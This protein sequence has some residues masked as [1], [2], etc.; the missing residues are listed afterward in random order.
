[1]L[2]ILQMSIIAHNFP[3]Y[4]EVYTIVSQF[5]K[6]KKKN[7]TEKESLRKLS[8]FKDKSA[9]AQ[10]QVWVS[11]FRVCSHQICATLLNATILVFLFSPSEIATT[12]IL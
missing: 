4:P 5:I 10:I 11:D 6:K 12:H 9:R 8:K 3:T 1:M 7:K 2:S